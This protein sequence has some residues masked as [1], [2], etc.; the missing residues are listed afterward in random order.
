[1]YLLKPT[2][3]FW[4]YSPLAIG[5]D[6]HPFPRQAQGVAAKGAT[7]P[8]VLPVQA[9]ELWQIWGV[10]SA[11]SPFPS[12]EFSR[13][14]SSS[15]LWESC[16]SLCQLQE[17]GLTWASMVPAAPAQV[18]MRIGNGAALSSPSSA[19]FTAGA[20]LQ[21]TTHPESNAMENTE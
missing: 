19:F 18:N 14:Q 12:L 8:L 2:F 16:L 10:F 5:R 21:C 13:S 7:A 6:I 15:R 20:K 4:C 11:L 9:G 3:R 1:M 17:K